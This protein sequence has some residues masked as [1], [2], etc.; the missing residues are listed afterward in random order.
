ME[1]KS[2]IFGAE[3]LAGMKEMETQLEFLA[4]INTWRVRIHLNRL[5]Y[6][7]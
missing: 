4:A 2:T 5:K 6:S 3:E 1:K 7:T